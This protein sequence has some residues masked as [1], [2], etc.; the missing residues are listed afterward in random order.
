TSHPYGIFPPDSSLKNKRKTPGR[1]RARTCYRRWLPFL[2]QHRR[3]WEDF[4]CSLRSLFQ[5]G[6]FIPRLLARLF[7]TALAGIWT[8]PARVGRDY[9]QAANWDAVYRRRALAALC[10]QSRFVARNTR[11][12]DHALASTA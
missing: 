7:R 12:G 1:I 8:I 3:L 11:S 2:V 5:G 9:D 6:L 4:L 10:F